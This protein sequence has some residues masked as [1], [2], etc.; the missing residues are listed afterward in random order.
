MLGD[1]SS[2]W[3]IGLDGTIGYWNQQ[4][5]D[6]TGFTPEQLRH[7]SWE[8]L[9]PEDTEKVQR[10]WRE[11][12]ASGAPYEMEHRIRG[13]DGAFRRFL[14]RGIPVHDPHG[15]VLEYF[16]THTDV[17]ELRRSGEALRAAQADLARMSRCDVGRALGLSGT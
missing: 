9:H 12:F 16:G 1:S 13:R 10:A 5:L 7:R 8:A 17:E 4:F 6:Y 11:A 2:C 15:R 14:C 3:S